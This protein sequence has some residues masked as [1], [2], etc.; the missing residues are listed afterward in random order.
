V[1]AAIAP[2]SRGIHPDKDREIDLVGTGKDPAH[3]DGAE[4]FLVLHPALFNDDD[5]ARPSG[6][7]AANEARAM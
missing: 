5:L 3:R 6:E 7:P 2:G 4:K 1:T